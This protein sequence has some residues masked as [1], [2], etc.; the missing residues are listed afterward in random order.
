MVVLHDHSVDHVEGNVV[1]CACGRA[2]FPEHVRIER[3]I[4]KFV[5]EIFE[6]EQHV[7]AAACQR[8]LHRAHQL[9]LLQ[10]VE[11]FLF[12]RRV[13]GQD[14]FRLHA[15]AQRADEGRRVFTVDGRR[16]FVL[17]LVVFD[18]ERRLRAETLSRQHKRLWFKNVVHHDSLRSWPAR[19]GAGWSITGE[20]E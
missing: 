18:D 11:Q 7:E 15:R 19:N 13:A 17:M 10:T 14:F 2:L 3:A 8:G 5:G 1:T 6:F 16:K 20:P 12:V 4:Q 9:Q